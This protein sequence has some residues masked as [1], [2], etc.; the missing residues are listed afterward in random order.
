MLHLLAGRT[1]P[2]IFSI[3]HSKWQQPSEIHQLLRLIV[4]AQAHT[5]TKGV[6]SRGGLGAT[7]RMAMTRPCANCH[8]PAEAK[9]GFAMS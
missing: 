7:P 9:P 1:T 6:P 4:S 3:S 2:Q 5:I 8:L